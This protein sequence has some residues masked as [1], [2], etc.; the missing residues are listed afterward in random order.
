MRLLEFFNSSNF[1]TF[2]IQICCLPKL[3]VVIVAQLEEWLLWSAVRIPISAKFHLVLLNRKD[4][5]K[6]KEAGKG[7]SQETC[8]SG[9]EPFESGS[10][11]RPEASDVKVQQFK[12]LSVT[13][14]A[15]AATAD[16]NFRRKLF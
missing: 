3:W 16:L 5:K 10:G 11:N 1:L 13:P 8:K 14:A 15:S 12:I 9:L 4:A 6:E 7:S 2:R